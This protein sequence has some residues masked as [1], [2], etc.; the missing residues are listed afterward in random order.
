[1][2]I[3]EVAEILDTLC[4]RFSNSAWSVEKPLRASLLAEP[5]PEAAKSMNVKVS[6]G[7][8]HARDARKAAGG[9]VLGQWQV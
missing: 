8:A 7:N 6:S 4:Q 3:R 1:V 9:W 2:S 5:F